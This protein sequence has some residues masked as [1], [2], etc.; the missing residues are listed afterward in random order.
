M[1]RKGWCNTAREVDLEGA[2]VFPGFTDSHQHLEGVGRR[3]ETLSLFGIDSLDKRAAAIK[4]W[5]ADVPP[6]GL[7]LGHGWIEREWQGER[8]FLICQDVDRF[9][10]SKPLFMPLADGVSALVN[11]KALNMAGLNWDTPDPEGGRFERDVRASSLVM[12]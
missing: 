7:I 8:R 3:T 12:S 6:G 2:T 4:Q 11:I 9:T 5:A 10:E 1:A